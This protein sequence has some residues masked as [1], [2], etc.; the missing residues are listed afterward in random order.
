M[1]LVHL[2]QPTRIR[3]APSHMGGTFGREF[4]ATASGSWCSWRIISF[5]LPFQTWKFEGRDEPLRPRRWQATSTRGFSAWLEARVTTQV[6]QTGHRVN[7]QLDVLWFG[8]F[9]IYYDK[10]YTLRLMLVY[11]HNTFSLTYNDM[12][13][14]IHDQLQSKWWFRMP[15]V[16]ACSN[17]RREQLSDEQLNS[18]CRGAARTL[19]FAFS[20]MEK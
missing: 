2:C 11:T 12:H 5:C 6:S 8:R 18:F 10:V 1:L 20:S 14:Y 19:A 16:P 17:T 4:P 3:P 15:C 9:T 7:Q 13:V